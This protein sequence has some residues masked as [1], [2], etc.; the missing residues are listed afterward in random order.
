MAEEEGRKDAGAERQRGSEGGANAI[1]QMRKM[2]MMKGMWRKMEEE[3]GG[4]MKGGVP[5]SSKGGINEDV[6][7][8]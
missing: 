2:I 5:A 3:E 7:S 8:L 1:Q 4:A 6:L